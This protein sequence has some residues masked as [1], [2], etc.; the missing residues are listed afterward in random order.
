MVGH[1]LLD[2]TY[3]LMYSCVIHTKLLSHNSGIHLVVEI[4]E[5]ACI[6]V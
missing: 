2:I 4:Q 1:I 3:A 6:D 5:T